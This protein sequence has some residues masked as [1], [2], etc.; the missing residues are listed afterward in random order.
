MTCMKLDWN[1]PVIFFTFAIST[2]SQYE[3]SNLRLFFVKRWAGSVKTSFFY[4][5]VGQTALFGG[6]YFFVISTTSIYIQEFDMQSKRHLITITKEEEWCNQLVAHVFWSIGAINYRKKKEP[7]EDND[8]QKKKKKNNVSD[9]SI[10]RKEG[11]AW[12]QWRPKEKEE[13]QCI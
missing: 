8:D 7:H 1:R 13:K 12:R 11:I 3:L 4:S 5:D 9:W 10:I 6:L 2:L